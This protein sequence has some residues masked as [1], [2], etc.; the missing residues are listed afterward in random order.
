METARDRY[1]AGSCT[2]VS[3]S[4]LGRAMVA[5]YGVPPD[6]PAET[7][8]RLWRTK[9]VSEEAYARATARISSVGVAP[10]VDPTD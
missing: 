3:M 1:M 4:D 7:L 5:M 9:P 10:E 2:F 6:T 8:E